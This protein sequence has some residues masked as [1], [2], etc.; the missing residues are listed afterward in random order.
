MSNNIFPHMIDQPGACIDSSLFATSAH[1]LDA[2]E[3][4]SN[5]TTTERMM[6][7]EELIYE[8]LTVYS[9]QEKRLY[10]CTNKPENA[11][12][13]NDCTWQ[14]CY[15]QDNISTVK[16][17]ENYKEAETYAA[18]ALSG[19]TVI[20][21]NPTDNDNTDGTYI[22]VNNS[23]IRLDNRYTYGVEYDGNSQT[24]RIGGISKGTTLSSL[25]A[26][27]NKGDIS[28]IIDK[29]LFAPSAPAIILS[30][31]EDN[32]DKF[33][34]IFTNTQIE[35]KADDYGIYFSTSPD[36]RQWTFSSAEY[37]P[38]RM[39]IDG[40]LT[41]VDALA[42]Y[43]IVNTPID[44]DD[45][46]KKCEKSIRYIS[47]EDYLA[48]PLS[49]SN[50]SNSVIHI[51]KSY[52]DKIGGTTENALTIFNITVQK[53]KDSQSYHFIAYGGS[54]GVYN[55]TYQTRSTA[56]IT[57]A[58]PSISFTFNER[59]NS[60]D[61]I[62]G[63]VNINPQLGSGTIV[64]I[65]DYNY[66]VSIYE[67]ID[68]SNDRKIAEVSI[69]DTSSNITNSNF[70]AGQKF[71][72][73]SNLDSSK[74]Y[75]N[76]THYYYATLNMIVSYPGLDNIEYNPS[77][78]NSK[79]II[80]ALNL[81][82]YTGSSVVES[83]DGVLY[84]RY[85]FDRT[86]INSDYDITYGVIVNEN[87]TSDARIVYTLGDKMSRLATASGR[88]SATLYPIS[89]KIRNDNTELIGVA[90]EPIKN[91]SATAPEL[92][93]PQYTVSATIGRDD[94]GKVKLSDIIV[95]GSNNN[96]LVEG[97]KLSLNSTV[98]TDATYK[99]GDVVDDIIGLEFSKDY[100]ITLDLINV[101]LN[102]GTYTGITS[103]SSP[104]Y[105][106]GI[107]F[108][109]M[110]FNNTT[111]TND[112]GLTLS[113]SINSVSDDYNRDNIRVQIQESTATEDNWKT[114]SYALED[115]YS[116]GIKFNT[117][118]NIR[119]I[120]NVTRKDNVVDDNVGTNKVL[121]TSITN[122]ISS[123]NPVV[124][125]I[126]YTIS[127]DYDNPILNNPNVIISNSDVMTFTD[128]T[129]KYVL[130]QN[131]NIITNTNNT[132]IIDY[133]TVYTLTCYVSGIA[134]D[135]LTQIT[136]LEVKSISISK[137]ATKPTMELKEINGLPTTNN[138]VTTEGVAVG[139][140][141][142]NIKLAIEAGSGS[143][144]VVE[145]SKDS[146]F[147]TLY[148][149]QTATKEDSEVIVNISN[150]TTTY[151]IDCP[152]WIR[153]YDNV[154]PSTGANIIQGVIR[155]TY[156]APVVTADFYVGLMVDKDNFGEEC[157]NYED[158]GEDT[159][160]IVDSTPEKLDISLD[161]WTKVY[162]PANTPAGI[163]GYLYV[164]V[165]SDAYQ[166]EFALNVA[167]NVGGLRSLNS[168][169]I[170][171]NG[172]SLSR[173]YYTPGSTNNS[174]S[175]ETWSTSTAVFIKITKIS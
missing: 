61:S 50:L 2:K 6:T 125:N 72:L 173:Y 19:Q 92:S 37:V 14:V 41:E 167:G 25:L 49:Y 146:T 79:K 4:V 17:C 157:F 80:Y 43:E 48:N 164:I 33:H 155:F 113:Y 59:T 172:N 32:V 160:V 124:S 22:V 114:I 148:G 21:K 85:Q 115:T 44:I 162:S 93:G 149:R 7:D 96:S 91:T 20:V 88:Y 73:S 111:I 34:N 69:N 47:Y 145:V 112:N 168:T 38:D 8:G 130:T 119:L 62:T 45:Y 104:T 107:Q 109:E 159:P 24:T 101:T 56:H 18:T 147:S 67:Y 150:F 52:F 81:G 27:T 77:S 97:Y 82:E 122:S 121:A 99:P 134:T 75:N 29:L 13:A 70:V 30:L 83:I 3:V 89:I 161:E 71:E 64:P 151:N 156:T 108:K 154:T 116:N 58:N 68:G 132:W 102:G 144:I 66:K 54:K 169:N 135:G 35:T 110:S 51:S 65:D 166:V 53:L 57:Y 106:L 163:G 90:L 140:S 98:L 16:E 133:N 55:K 26:A 105:N 152:V 170:P 40:V 117:T 165:P 118:Y 141:V 76:E 9:I 46:N 137:S 1:P 86:D 42:K 63:V 171:Y 74:G 126:T 138:K 174:I 23:L 128:L 10:I 94:N 175:G 103:F 120:A 78:I 143:N 131:G 15:S 158:Y 84:Y 12:S 36:I 129:Y 28:R 11:V 39:V 123:I 142:N 60:S 136:D 139:N 31:R 100:I 5:W 87:N 127:N 153:I 95:N